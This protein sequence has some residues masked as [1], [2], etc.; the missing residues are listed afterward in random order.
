[1]S[2]DNLNEKINTSKSMPWWGIVLLVLLFPVWFS[3][4]C[5]VFALTLTVAIMLL[6]VVIVLWCLDLVFFALTLGAIIAMFIMLAKGSILSAVIYA[7][8]AL[9]TGGLCILAFI[10]C[11]ALTKW[12]IAGTCLSVKGIVCR[13]SRKKEA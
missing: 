12:I 9:V 13:L 8:I 1:M 3:I 11:L 4:L 7:G 6:V 2:E 5:T 10:G